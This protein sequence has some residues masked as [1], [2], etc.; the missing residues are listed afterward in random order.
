MSE[1]EKLLYQMMML[2]HKEVMTVISGVV[3]KATADAIFDNYNNV[4]N[5]LNEQYR[6]LTEEKNEGK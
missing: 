1:A 6:K 3:P 4:F 2:L 5:E